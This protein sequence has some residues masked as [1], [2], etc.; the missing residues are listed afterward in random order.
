MSLVPE[1]TFPAAA[2]WYAPG[3]SAVSYTHSHLVY[4]ARNCVVAVRL[5]RAGGRVVATLNAHTNRV[6][7]V[8]ALPQDAV[9]AYLLETAFSSNRNKNVNS[10]DNK[11]TTNNNNVNDTNENVNDDLSPSSLYVASGSA[12]ASVRVWHVKSQRVVAAHT[13]VGSRSKQ[14]LFNA[15]L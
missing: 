2:N 3:V 5:T 6:T 11:N 12:D 1:Q 13:Q 4:G 9:S 7:A 15:L 8:C 14:L 10:N